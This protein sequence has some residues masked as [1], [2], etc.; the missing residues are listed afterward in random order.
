MTSLEGRM[1]IRCSIVFVHGFN[2]HSKET[3]FSKPHNFYWA[4]E[5]RN[6]I[7]DARILTFGY[8]SNIRI[9]ATKNLMGLRDH[10]MNL[11]ARLRNERASFSVYQT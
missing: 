5:I 2:G 3:W 1:L 8:D 7:K 4:W 9:I 10:A 6:L 11:L